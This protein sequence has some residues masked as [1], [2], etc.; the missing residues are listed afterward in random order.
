MS[1]PTNDLLQTLQQRGF[2]FLLWRGILAVLIGLLLLISPFG[3]ATVFGIIVG[4][5]MVLDGGVAAALSLQLRKQ[6]APWGWTMT[7][8]IIQILAG[9]AIILFPVSFAVVSAF[10][11][12]GFLAI[13]MVLSGVAQLSAPVQERSGWTIAVGLL[14]I[15]LGVVL[16]VFAITN[17]VSNVVSLAWMA[18]VAAMM[19][20]IALII[21]SVKVRNLGK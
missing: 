2:R 7:E 14:D 1:S 15:V 8:G 3:S 11:I 21:V 5:W 4:V 19:F 13:G 10:F 18:G 20:G 9:I 12:L 17:P 16:G 6:N